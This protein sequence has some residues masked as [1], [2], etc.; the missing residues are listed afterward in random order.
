MGN[1]D[2]V[3]DWLLEDTNPAVAYR[4]RIELLGE[5]GDSVKAI[6]WMKKIL[7]DGWQD[8]KGL[9]ATYYY[10]A[11]AE[12][13]LT[14]ADIKINKSKAID[15][16]KAGKF[17]YGCGDFMKLRALIMPGMCCLARRMK[18]ENIF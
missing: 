6:Q 7:P 1:K 3:I 4:T 10:N 17:N 9:W 12:S 11:I 8:V 5:K 15:T 16:Y 14:R 2:S 18:M 13:G